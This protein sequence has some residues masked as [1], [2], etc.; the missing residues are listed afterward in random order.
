[1]KNLLLLLL[2]IPLV[3]CD[4]EANNTN[5]LEYPLD[6]IWVFYKQTENDSIRYY[7]KEALSNEEKDLDYLT[8]ILF[9][10]MEIEQGYF[11]YNS[12]KKKSDRKPFSDLGEQVTFSVR[13]KNNIRDSLVYNNTIDGVIAGVKYSSTPSIK[14]VSRDTL[15]IE[16]KKVDSLG[17]IIK[18]NNKEFYL[19]KP[20]YSSPEARAILINKKTDLDL[21]LITQ[22][23]Y[24]SIKNKLSRYI[25]D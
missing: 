9:N 12:N 2:F 4:S 11:K 24:D 6:D 7:R 17:T 22:K 21:E 14:F 1:L 18:V 19:R 5:K 16:T 10:N 25:A 3:S 15:V 8:Y 13:F 20:M 23:Q